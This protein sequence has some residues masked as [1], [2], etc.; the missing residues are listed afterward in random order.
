MFIALL[1]ITT[2][3]PK[4][5][6]IE[7][8]KIV[9]GHDFLLSTNNDDEIFTINSENEAR[10]EVSGIFKE[11]SRNTLKQRKKEKIKQTN[12]GDF[13]GNDAY[14]VVVEFSK[15]KS[16]FYHK[17]S[18]KEAKKM[19][20]QAMLLS[21]RAFVKS[22]E[23]EHNQ[24]KELYTE[25]LALEQQAAYFYQE[26]ADLQPT[27]SW[28]FR[29][30]ANLAL[31]AEDLKAAKKLA[32]EG[33]RHNP[34]E[35][36]QV[37]LEE[38]LKIALE[39]EAFL[40]YL[41]IQKETIQENELYIHWTGVS[42]GYGIAPWKEIKRKI[43]TT[44]S[45]LYRLAEL[46]TGKDF[47]AS[48]KAPS[49]ILALVKPNVEALLPGSFGVRLKL[50]QNLEQVTLFPEAKAGEILED[51]VECLRLILTEDNTTK[52]KEKINNEDYFTNFINLTKELAP[53]GKQ[54]RQLAIQLKSKKVNLDRSLKNKIKRW[55]KTNSSDDEGKFL[56]VKGELRT[57]NATSSKIS[58]YDTEEKKN[59]KIT[60]PAGLS[61][62]VKSYWEEEVV[63]SVKVLS[64]G[65]FKL[66][67]IEEPS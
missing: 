1:L 20:R 3:Q 54:L 56:T 15:P 52:L 57:A 10:L 53:D 24:A 16:I 18:M 55:S 65:E 61:E 64:S 36:L 25:A 31:E 60:V 14:I 7:T 6:F 48:G 40:K 32:M 30:A 49:D 4:Y 8:S 9:N 66:L 29:S 62:I 50:G 39:K 38:T 58:I 27:R 67:E 43:D 17:Q 45:L 41:K 19:H 34:P 44:E 35:E 11:N 46:K 63:V 51:L 22:E 2:L 47:R 59:Y 5:K 12:K 26:R 42:T 33:L 23:G 21:Q 13:M 37:Q 28:L